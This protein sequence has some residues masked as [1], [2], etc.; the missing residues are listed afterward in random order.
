MEYNAAHIPGASLIPRR[1]LE[2]E[3]SRALPYKGVQVVL[4]DENGRNAERAAATLVRGGY[5]NVSVLKGGVNRWA[6]DG[7]PTEWGVNV[8][9][10]TF[11]EEIEL[12]H[13]VPTISADDLHDRIER[14]D[15]LVILDT[16]TPEEFQRLCI[17]GGRSVPGGELA[18]RIA[19]I[20]AEV[21]EDA[22]V[23]VNCAGR[24]RSIIGTRLLQRMGVE[25]LY[26]LENG[27]AGWGL[28]GY[29]LE[30]NAD[31]TEMPEPSPEGASEAERFGRRVAAEDGV[32]IIDVVKL[33]ELMG[34]RDAETVYLVD[35]RLR[36]EFGAGHIP[37]SSWMPGGQ[38][39][40]TADATAVV[41]NAPIVF[42]CDGITRAAIAASWY[43]QMG[44]S[45]V[46]ALDGGTT[47]WADAGLELVVKDV[48]PEPAVES[49]LGLDTAGAGNRA[50]TPDN[51][52]SDS[53]RTVLFVG[54][55]AEFAAG[56]VQDA[57]W[58]SRGVLEEEAGAAIPDFGSPV[59]VTCDD[60][61]DSAALGAATLSELG[62][63]DV[64]WLKGGMELWRSEGRSVEKGLTGV[65]S[66]PLDVLPA[67][68]N[69]SYGDMINYLRWETALVE[70][71]ER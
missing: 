19:D 54:T 67:G 5:S 70:Q 15:K 7:R 27:T 51:L 55:S 35:V 60:G 63:L 1:R 43:R 61:G 16:R 17:P 48:G 46:Y 13:D 33:R 71:P 28:A 41:H 32:R 68:T 34:Q 69:R 10:K 4:C 8:P 3:V 53:S 29:E 22:T 21:G 65:M 18:L 38:A 58:V 30:A 47:A 64:V 14:G 45:D 2:F 62:Y 57:S 12:E 9:S 26:G 44:K 31:R 52:T 6:A 66:A 20:R 23:V 11:G 40:Q 39:V 24:T 37:G 25:D 50:I 36:D 49:V 42:I 56:H 59:A